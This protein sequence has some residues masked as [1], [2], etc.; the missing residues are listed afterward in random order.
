MSSIGRSGARRFIEHVFSKEASGKSSSVFSAALHAY[1][2]AVGH[3]SLHMEALRRHTENLWV[4]DHE[5][6]KPIGFAHGT[7]WKNI[8]PSIETSPDGKLFLTVK[9]ASENE[10]AM[11]VKG[12]DASG[13]YVGAAPQARSYAAS[14]ED[15]VVLTVRSK[16]GREPV[17]DEATGNAH[18]EPGTELEIL[19]IQKRRTVVEHP[20]PGVYEGPS[21]LG[22]LGKAIYDVA[23]TR[24]SSDSAP[25]PEG[26]DARSER[27]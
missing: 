7:S 27:A 2:E 11:N 16:D 9:A 6:E 17:M 3:R 25:P 18:Y 12:D 15:G 8:E 13:L 21:P 24:F 26:P 23:R 20:H 1:D 4:T 10:F 19:K 22:A 14:F 5:T